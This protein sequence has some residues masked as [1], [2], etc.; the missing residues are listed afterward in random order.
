M[1][2]GLNLGA[3]SHHHRTWWPITRRKDVMRGRRSARSQRGQVFVLVQGAGG[4]RPSSG[5]HAGDAHGD[6][7]T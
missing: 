6:C 5:V 2:F 7:G 3:P 1:G 4:S